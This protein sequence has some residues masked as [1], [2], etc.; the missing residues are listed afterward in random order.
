M[1]LYLKKNGSL[2]FA[3]CLCSTLTPLLAKTKLTTE[4]IDEKTTAV[5]LTVHLKKNDFVLKKSIDISVNN[6][7]VTLSAWSTNEQA[8]ERYEPAFKETKKLFEKSFTI[9][10]NAQVN[11][12]VETKTHLYLS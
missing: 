6:P 8:I 9:N 4:Y 1:S 2:F 10:L 5:S 7:N 11:N 12:P 3:L